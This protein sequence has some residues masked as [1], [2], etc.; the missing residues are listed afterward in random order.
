MCPVHILLGHSTFGKD[1]E[2]VCLQGGDLLPPIWRKRG[3]KG[4]HDKLAS[5]TAARKEQVCRGQIQLKHKWHRKCHRNFEIGHIHEQ[6]CKKTPFGT[7]FFYFECTCNAI[8][9]N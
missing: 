2:G 9:R 7:K 8:F 4:P 1:K 3:Q 6:L 5:C